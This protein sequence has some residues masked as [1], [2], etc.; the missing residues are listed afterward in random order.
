MSGSGPG[1]TGPAD[2]P[3][4]SDHPDRAIAPASPSASGPIDPPGRPSPRWSRLRRRARLAGLGARRGVDLAATRTR[5]VAAPAERR[6]R[7]DEAYA[8]R[9]AADA[10]RELGHMKGAVMKLGQM[11]SFIGDGLP[12][13]AQDALAQLQAE[14]PPMAPGLAAEVVRAELGADPTVL[15]RRWDEVPVAAA[16]IGQV[17]R[18]TLPDGRE[19]AVKVQ[20][21]GIEDAIGSDLADGARIGALLSAVTLKSVDVPA[22]A[23]ELRHRLLD[24]LDYRIEA[25]NQQEFAERW[26]GHRSQHVP[27]VIAERSGRRVLTSEWADGLT[28]A[29]FVADAPEPARQAAGEAIFRFAQQSILHDR[30]FNGDPHPGNYRF[31]PDGRVTF[32]DFGLV[33]RLDPAEHAGLMVVL[34]GV[35]AHDAEATT[36]AMVGAGFLAPDHGLDPA[37]VFACVSAPYRAYFDDEFTFTPAYT[38][39]ALRSLLDVR[40]PYADVL[41]AL[42]MPPSFVLIDRVVWGVS[43]VLGR[44]HA[45]NHW[46]AIVLAYRDPPA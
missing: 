38:G 18:A 21:P 8:I 16:S 24:E 39:D 36:T 7:L 40:G 12:P 2:Q 31:A 5:S 13:E 20:Y 3:D 34:D 29:Q 14:A 45:T 27:A 28:F 26:A 6:A 30:V 44:L 17:H 32:L 15:F 42:D 11:L 37:R 1:P 41:A 25:A 22:L 23:E 33:K 4:Q 43:A 35:L 10:A 46:R 19:V 9:S